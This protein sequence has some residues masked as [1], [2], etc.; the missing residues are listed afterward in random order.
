MS[1]LF[2]IDI[3]CDHPGCLTWIF[4]DVGHSTRSAGLMGAARRRAREHGWTHSGGKDYCPEHTPK[5]T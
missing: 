2:T 5:V 1:F 3:E 4:G